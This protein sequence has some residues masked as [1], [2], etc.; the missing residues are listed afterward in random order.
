MV[1]AIKPVHLESIFPVSNHMSPKIVRTGCCYPSRAIGVVLLS[2]QLA[3]RFFLHLW[4]LD[5]VECPLL[6]APDSLTVS[7]LLFIEQP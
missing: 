2:V 7:N 3:F 6:A 4:A 1:E 5:P